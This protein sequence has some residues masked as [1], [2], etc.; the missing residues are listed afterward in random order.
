MKLRA[1]L[2]LCLNYLARNLASLIFLPMSL[3]VFA[4]KSPIDLPPPPPK[5]EAFRLEDLI[6]AGNREKTLREEWALYQSRL[7]AAFK[8]ASN[9]ETSSDNHELGQ[10]AW[11]RFINTFA[12]DNPY[13]EQDNLLMQ[14]AMAVTRD[15]SKSAL[16]NVAAPV[17]ETEEKP[18][19][20]V[21]ES[22]ESPPLAIDGGEVIQQSASDDTPEF[23]SKAELVQEST[24]PP[25]EADPLSQQNIAPEEIRISEDEYLQVLAGEGQFIYFSDEDRLVERFVSNLKISQLSE[26]H[27]ELVVAIAELLE[28]ESNL[29]DVY[30]QLNSQI[31]SDSANK[32]SA[33][34]LDSVRLFLDYLSAKNQRRFKLDSVPWDKFD[35]SRAGNFALSVRTLIE[36]SR[37]K[38]T[39]KRKWAVGTNKKKPARGAQRILDQVDRLR[40]NYSGGLNEE[41]LKIT[42]AIT[43]Q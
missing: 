18:S 16:S 35:S 39:W 13:S 9:F 22:E 14:R 26:N 20:L 41:L 43:R 29:S 3:S 23:S 8:E 19:D 25:S 37:D 1:V 7:E 11:Q 21:V 28:Q 27:P 32:V 24:F 31:S 42:V 4:S 15:S 2:I 36:S 30:A 10:I 5:V 6:A 12:A 38:K 40:S 17:S 34:E 33:V